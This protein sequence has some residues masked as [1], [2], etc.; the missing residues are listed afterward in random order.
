MTRVPS[1][2]I[3]F[4]WLKAV[5]GLTA[6][7]RLW[8]RRCPMFC[9]SSSVPA[10]SGTISLSWARSDSTPKSTGRPRPAAP[11]IGP[12]WTETSVLRSNQACGPLP[13]SAHRTDD[14][15][16]QIDFRPTSSF[17]GVLSRST[18]SFSPSRAPSDVGLRVPVPIRMPGLVGRGVHHRT[19]C[20]GRAVHEDRSAPA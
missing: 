8:V 13:D 5:S 17:Q 16:H 11:R 2:L 6:L 1:P 7:H 20:A 12:T 19:D 18:N 9:P 10:P 4:V 3:R 15:E 14:I